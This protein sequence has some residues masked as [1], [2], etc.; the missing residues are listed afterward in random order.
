M[1]GSLAPKIARS[2]GATES[3]PAV[4][5]GSKP[6]TEQYILAEL[7]SDRLAEAGLET[8]VRSGMGSMILFEALASGA[9]DCYVDYSGTIWANVMKREDNPPRGQMLQEMTDWVKREQGIVCLGALGF[10]NTYALAM[11]QD[12]AESRGLG[13]IDDLT[14]VA[15]HLLIGSDYEFFSRP[16][17]LAL[18][19]SYQLEFRELITM[20]PTLMYTAI[21]QNEVDVISAYST[22]GRIAASDL[23]VLQDTKQALPPYDAVLLLSKAASERADLM[24]QLLG[25]IG[26]IDSKAMRQANKLVDT[27]G[28]TIDSAA[29]FLRDGQASP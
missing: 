18:Q 26:S 17:W 22:D 7:I 19:S 29:G 5:I 11:R 13:T 2:V 6:F 14:T 15:P 12:D 1:G 10:E 8:D 16:E 4:V 27:D 9:V 3:E 23:M 20:D 25:L 21:A 24:A 28:L